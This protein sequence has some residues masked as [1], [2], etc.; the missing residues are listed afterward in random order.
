[1]GLSG[2]VFRQLHRLGQ[3]STEGGGGGLQVEVGLREM[4]L[5]LGIEGSI[6]ATKVMVEGVVLACEQCR[7]YCLGSGR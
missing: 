6:L 5:W 4:V 1:M 7:R 3:P 2:E